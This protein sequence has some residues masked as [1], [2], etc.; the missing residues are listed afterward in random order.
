MWHRMTTGTGRKL[1]IG[2]LEKA[3]SEKLAFIHKEPTLR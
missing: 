1:L 3:V 2:Y